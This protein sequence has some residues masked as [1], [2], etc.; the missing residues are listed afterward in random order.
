DHRTGPAAGGETKIPGRYGNVSLLY[1]LFLGFS[2]Y[3][4]G[5]RGGQFLLDADAARFSHEYAIHSGKYPIT[6]HPKRGADRSGSS[7]HRDDAAVRWFLRY[8]F[9]YY[10]YD[11][12]K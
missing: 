5:Y 1:V 4:A 2:Y 3:N 10:L 11:P 12:A 9:D 8:R 7:L 6:F